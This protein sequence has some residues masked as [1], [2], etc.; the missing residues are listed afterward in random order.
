MTKILP[1]LL[2]ILMAPRLLVNWKDKTWDA[3][4][5]RVEGLNDSIQS[6][7]E[8]GRDGRLKLQYKMCVRKAMWFDN[9]TDPYLEYHDIQYDPI[10][11]GYNVIKDRISDE[12]EP[13]SVA[14]PSRSEAISDFVTVKDLPM[15]LF[16]SPLDIFERSGSTYISIGGSYSCKGSVSRT[17]ARI[18]S[19]LTLGMRETG[20]TEISWSDFDVSRPVQ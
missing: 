2:V 17:W 7:L 5:F 15:S 9:C 12:E 16:K 11:E 18:S 13:V 14:L 4:V 20:R 19:V 8:N 6:C 3:L 1:F 10:T